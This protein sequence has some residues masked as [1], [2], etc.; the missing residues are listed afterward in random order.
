MKVVIDTNIVFS[1]F[2]NANGKIGKILLDQQA[3]FEFYTCDFLRVEINK[4][5]KK[6]L[7]SSKITEKEL[8]ELDILITNPI[9]FINE[10]LL[11][12]ELLEKTSILLKG[13]DVN[14][15]PFVALAT[16]LKAVLW[17][18]DKVLYEGLKLKKFKT[19]YNTL[20]MFNIMNT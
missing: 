7:I 10:K 4:H 11:P 12:V 1:S 20:D 3:G 18:G 2:I 13:I 17:T 19:V 6:L 9:T 8:N 5:K 15:T 16:H 14:D